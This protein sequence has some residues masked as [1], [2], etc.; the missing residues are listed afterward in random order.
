MKQRLIQNKKVDN[1]YKSASTHGVTFTA[2]DPKRADEKMFD[3]TYE[4][5]KA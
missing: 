4:P 1:S 5:V 2:L 3:L